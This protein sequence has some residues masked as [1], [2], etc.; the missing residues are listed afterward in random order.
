MS[1]I[2]SLKIYHDLSNHDEFKAE[3]HR[4]G[5]VYGFIHINEGEIKKKYI[6]SSKDL[7]QR[8]LDHLKGRDSNIRLQRA[9][10]KHGIQNFK[11]AIYYIDNDPNIRLTDIETAV[12][13]NFPFE[14]LYNYFF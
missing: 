6:G 1:G 3:L 14:E 9:I 7:Y 10:E 2:I 13:K 4:I 12:I 5:G 8:F 11:F